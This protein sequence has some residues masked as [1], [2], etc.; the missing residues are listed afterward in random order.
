METS[1]LLLRVLVPGKVE[2]RRWTLSHQVFTEYQASKDEEGHAM[3]GA[4][5]SCPL[6]ALP[7]QAR[8]TP[9]GFSCLTPSNPKG[10][11]ITAITNEE[12]LYLPEH[13][14]PPTWK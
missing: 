1:H 3:G 2:Q 5:T 13:S 14:P 9:G 8:P 11:V 6:L 12:T 7:S 4:E 10:P